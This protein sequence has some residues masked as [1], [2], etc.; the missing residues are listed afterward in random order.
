[1][2]NRNKQAGSRLELDIVSRLKE[3]GY[4]AVTARYA[5]RMMDDKGIDIVSDFPFAIQCK[6][7]INQPNCHQIFTEKECDVIFFRK[8]EKQGKRFFAKGEYAMLRL[9]DLLNLIG[10]KDEQT[11]QTSTKTAKKP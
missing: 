11:K 1:M 8:M 2:A 6:A 9:D 10:N 7:S 5:S 3:M 4:E